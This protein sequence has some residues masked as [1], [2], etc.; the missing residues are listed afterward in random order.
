[1]RY[2][3]KSFDFRWPT[4]YHKSS[5]EAIPLLAS[6]PVFVASRALH[7]GL[8]YSTHSYEE[9]CYLELALELYRFFNV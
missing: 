2:A 5:D 8:A 9:R 7:I 6:V 4:K 1:M 3:T